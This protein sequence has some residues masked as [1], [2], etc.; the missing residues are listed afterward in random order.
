M[1][2]SLDR[3]WRIVWLALAWLG[4]VALQLQQPTLWPQPA[5]AAVALVAVGLAAL[6]RRR[7]GSALFALAAAALALAA[8]A[9]T[10]CRAAQSLAERLPPALEGQD[11]VVTGVVA[12][13]PRL[14]SIGT[15]FVFE[16]ESATHA[17]APA[18]VPRRLSIGWYHGYDGESLIASP[19]QAI[20]AGDRWQLPLR[21]KQPH[22]VMNP[23]GFDLEL[24]LFEQGILASGYVR[25][26]ALWLADGVAHPVE[27]LRQRIRDAI[28]LRV[29]DSSA[30]GV[31]AALAVGDQAAIERDEWDLFR[32]TGVA[33]LTRA[34]A[35]C[36]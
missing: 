24:W 26:G 13:L 7:R 22:G 15:R 21:L 35:A 6:A 16:V 9:S 4:G 17:G 31:L 23:H 36:T 20:Q 25:P 28:L 12:E 18:A 1:A 5:S 29:A 19:P 10:D 30:A 34:S 2:R 3:G 14:S 11:I 33:H 8:F 32:T 27:R